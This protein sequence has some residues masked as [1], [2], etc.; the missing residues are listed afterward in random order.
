MTKIEDRLHAELSRTLKD[1]VGQ[2]F[3]ELLTIRLQK[4]RRRRVLLLA[5]ATILAAAFVTGLM[6]ELAVLLPI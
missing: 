1:D 3:V 6:L 4:R 2:N 5:L